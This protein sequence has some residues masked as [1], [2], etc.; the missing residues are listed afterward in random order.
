M[1]IERPAARNPWTWVPSLYFAQGIPYV[2][3]MT[4]S[5]IMY[6][7]LGISNSDIAFYTGWLYLPWVIKPLWSPFV[8]LFKTKRLWIVVMQVLLG[9]LLASVALTIPLPG[10]FQYT[11]VLLWLMAFSSATHD[12]AADGF[13][14]LGLDQHQQAAF[15]GVRSTFYRIA[16]IAAQGLLVILAGFIE[17]A[18]GLDPVELRVVAEPGAANAALTLPEPV[19]TSPGE[20]PLRVVADPADLHISTIVREKAEIDSIVRRARASNVGNGFVTAE[21]PAA[22]A[23]ADESWWD[24]AVVARLESFLRAHF[25]DPRTVKVQRAG[26]VGV[27][28]LR[29][30]GVPEAGRSIV[31]AVGRKS[32]DESVTLLEGARLVFDEHNWNKP[33]WV[34]FQLDPALRTRAETVFTATSGNIPLAWST[35]FAVLAVMFAIFCA[36]HKFMLPYPPADRP[37]LS[38]AANSIL[39]EFFRTFADFFRRKDIVVVM[40][41]LLFYRFAEAQLVTLVSPFLLDAREAGGLGLTTKQVG[42]AYGTV[43]ITALM[44]GG[45]VGGYVVARHG[46]HF[47]LW[48]MVIIM[49]SPDL[50]FVYLSHAQPQ[51]F[52]LINIAVAVEQF[53]YG[54]GFTAY[55]L[56]MILVA[57]GVHKTAHYAICTGFMALGMMLPRMFSGWLQETVGYRHF[58]I[59]VVISTIP[60]FLVAALVRIDPQFGRKKATPA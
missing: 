41:F 25:A 42:I 7:R 50:V 47:W 40:A 24:R 18:S 22:S 20:G 51:N 53:A 11:L 19:T 4:V 10:F 44:A 57:E 6:K 32:G 54:F 55:M 5:V 33:A 2:V 21:E 37:S 49:H 17:G 12:I 1:A 39:A 38:A 8:D 28:S 13:Y 36:Y 34:V 26:N 52:V 58:F 9:A 29:L 31:V 56:Y 48:P 60:G 45:L 43:G 35:V 30:S 23:A 46:L 15:V 3:V 27:I 59:W 16:T 14:M